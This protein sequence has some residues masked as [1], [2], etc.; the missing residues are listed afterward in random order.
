MHQFLIT[1]APIIVVVISIIAA[2]FAAAKTE[3]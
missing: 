3:L 2:F 1:Y